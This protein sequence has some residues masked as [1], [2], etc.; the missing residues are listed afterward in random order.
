[1]VFLNEALV[2][3]GQWK[4]LV[5]KCMQGGVDEER[6]RQTD[7]EECLSDMSGYPFVSLSAYLI[8]ENHVFVASAAGTR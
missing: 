1:M 5:V 3:H 7:R 2:W 4:G 8:C 6:G